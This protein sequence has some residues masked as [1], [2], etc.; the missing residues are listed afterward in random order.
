M[1]ELIERA[2]TLLAGITPGE[3]EDKS[4]SEDGLMGSVNCGQKHIALCNFFLTHDNERC[5]TANDTFANAAF[6]AAAPELVRGLC[7]EV[8]RLRG[9]RNRAKSPIQQKFVP[10]I[11]N[12]WL[13]VNGQSFSCK[14]G[15]QLFNQ[16]DRNVKIYFCN[17]CGAEHEGFPL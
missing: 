1:N 11:P 14:C 8:K 13:T 15:C 17:S 3:W 16:P 6:I 4:K 7:E 5:V 2:E 12:T 10:D 9:E